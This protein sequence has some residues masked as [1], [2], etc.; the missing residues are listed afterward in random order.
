MQNSLYEA[1]AASVN[2]SMLSQVGDLVEHEIVKIC[3]NH[4]ELLEYPNRV[5]YHIER[6]CINEV[7]WFER[8]VI[9]FDEKQISEFVLFVS[10][11]DNIKP[12]NFQVSITPE[13]DII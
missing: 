9:L 8:H 1:Y 5:A 3:D 4:P 2:E 10:K 13:E 6:N 7:K 11:N 12:P